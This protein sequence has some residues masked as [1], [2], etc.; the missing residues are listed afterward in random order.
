MAEPSVPSRQGYGCQ[1]EH[2]DPNDPEAEPGAAEAW[3]AYLLELAKAES[4][5]PIP[6]TKTPELP[7][8][9]QPEVS[10]FV[11]TE[12]DDAAISLSRT[13]PP[14][15]ATTS[16]VVT[17]DG[18]VELT[19]AQVCES[20]RIHRLETQA[21]LQAVEDQFR[22][23]WVA[24]GFSLDLLPENINGDNDNNSSSSTKKTAK[25]NSNSKD[26]DDEPL[27]QM[28][29]R[30]QIESESWN[31]HNRKKKGATA[32]GVSMKKTAPQGPDKE[33]LRKLVYLATK[34][35]LPETITSVVSGPNECRPVS[36]LSSNSLLPEMVQHTKY[37]PAD[38]PVI[39]LPSLT[40]EEVQA[41]MDSKIKEEQ[42]YKARVRALEDSIRRNE[43]LFE[44]GEEYLRHFE[45]MKAKQQTE[46]EDMILKRRKAVREEAA[47]RQKEDEERIK[48]EAEE[49]RRMEAAQA[50]ELAER[51]RREEEQRR[52]AEIR[53]A[54]RRARE[55]QERQQKIKEEAQRKK[56]EAARKAKE[57]QDAQQAVE[58]AAKE[59]AQ[60]FLQER[61][62]QKLEKE[63]QVQAQQAQ[64]VQQVQ[65]Q[66]AQAQPQRATAPGVVNEAG[67]KEMVERLLSTM[68]YATSEYENIKAKVI[69][70]L[71][72]K[73]RYLQ[74]IIKMGPPNPGYARFFSSYA[75]FRVSMGVVELR[76]KTIKTYYM[77]GDL[78]NFKTKLSKK[79][80]QVVG[81]SNG[82]LDAAKVIVGQLQAV[83]VVSQEKE[84]QIIAVDDFV[85]PQQKKT[86]DRG[87]PGIFLSLY[88]FIKII[89]VKAMTEGPEKIAILKALA[90]LLNSVMGGNA[91]FWRHSALTMILYFRFFEQSPTLFGAMGEK[92]DIGYRTIGGQIAESPTEVNGR[93]EVVATIF[94]LMGILRP[95]N[96][97]REQILTIVDVHRA[98]MVN[99]SVPVHLRDEL[100]YINIRTVMTIAPWTLRTYLGYEGVV[101]LESEIVKYCREETN[102]KLKALASLLMEQAKQL[103]SQGFTDRRK[104]FGCDEWRYWDPADVKDTNAKRRAVGEVVHPGQEKVD[105]EVTKGRIDRETA[106]EEKFRPP[107]A[108]SA[109]QR[110]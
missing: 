52:L 83:N 11:G 99:L 73:Q 63:K 66:Q 84:P 19:L 102:V 10:I 23:D 69:Q 109:P 42:D 60:L 24:R 94:C 100:H 65:A 57:A 107:G 12:G 77:N 103:H 67:I 88:N 110:M 104:E 78:T 79:V 35:Y 33:V 26:V 43:K 14:G 105:Y 13:T 90:T 61:E 34:R 15:A 72:W 45:E 58:L 18:K 49:K 9:L 56:D 68:P 8:V 97:K 39:N 16:T 47:R 38:P 25:S 7:L 74:G 1:R 50:K 101:K 81:N 48:R 96:T 98:L 75:E 54:E 89:L 86:G 91:T 70:L 71:A 59:K 28:L 32:K 5:L 92:K 93:A 62:R 85:N 53:E 95:S 31:P 37:L 22:K 2:L 6:I 80:M 55:E 29:E 51:L 21:E 36:S 82:Y 20:M 87:L 27:V 108:E 40:N 17:D 106:I 41:V 30:I 46:F 44:E 3:N 76:V 4:R 64:Q